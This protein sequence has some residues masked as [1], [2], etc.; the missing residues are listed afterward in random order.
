M[1]FRSALVRI[2]GFPATLIHGDTL[3]LDRWLWLRKRLVAVQPESRNLLDVGCGT[4][5]FT[6]GAARLGY[7]SIG[8]SWDARNQRVAQERA[9]ICGAEGAE[10]QIQDVRQLD[11][12]NDLNGNFDV[13]ICCECI[14]HILDD[15]KVMR[16]I[17]RCLKPGGTL[18]LTAP[19]SCFRPMAFDNEVLATVENGGHVR[20]GYVPEDLMRLCK[21]SGFEVAAVEYCSGLLSQKITSLMRIA[22]NLTSDLIG[23]PFFLPLR[24]I[25]PVFDRGVSRLTHWPDYSIALVARKA[26]SQPNVTP[27]TVKE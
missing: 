27:D 8:L 25:P 18:L 4:G 12:R 11:K 13:A 22:T 16:D 21:G 20:R 9:K 6:I 23:W 7:R 17:A 24:W 10:F 19:N 26:N 2:L 15:G 3:V 1:E 5:A 14:E